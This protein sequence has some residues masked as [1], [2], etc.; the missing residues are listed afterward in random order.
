MENTEVYDILRNEKVEGC[1]RYVDD[2]LIISKENHTD[3]NEVLSSF[4]SISP[5]LNFTVEHEQNNRINFLDLTIQKYVNK[6]TVSIYRKPTTTDATIPKDSCHSVEHKLAAIRYITNRINTYSLDSTSKQKEINTVKQ[7]AHSNKYDTTIVNKVSNNKPE[8]EQDGQNPKWT[9]FTY[10]GRE[11][12][13]ITKRFKNTNLKM[14]YT[15]NNNL[16]KLLDT[17][18]TTSSKNKFD[19]NGVYQLTSPTCLKKYI[20]QIG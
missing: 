14:A 10:V 7:T 12:R 11:T 1:F 18:K 19:K 4:N 17:Q 6:L 8:R 2:I 20:G 15:T 5:G 9:K 13:L 3:I 16:G